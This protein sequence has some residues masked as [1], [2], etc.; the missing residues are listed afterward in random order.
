MVRR[1][2]RH[3]QV[4]AGRVVALFDR[5]LRIYYFQRTGPPSGRVVTGSLTKEGAFGDLCASMNAASYICF[6][7]AVDSA[8]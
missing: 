8:S 3:E 7:P 4:G 5:I 2:V 6:G 1:P